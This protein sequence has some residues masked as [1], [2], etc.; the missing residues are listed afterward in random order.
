MQAEATRHLNG[1]QACQKV[2]ICSFG[3]L[4]RLPALHAISSGTVQLLDNYAVLKV[5][6]AAHVATLIQTG[7]AVCM[8]NHFQ[9][10]A[11]R[12]DFLLGKQAAC[13]SFRLRVFKTPRSN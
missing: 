11:A 4:A 8:A 1:K 6:S 2:T 7:H 3:Q 10:K 12:T 13:T 5:F 9:E